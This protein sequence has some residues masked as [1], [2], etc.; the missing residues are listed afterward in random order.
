M[1]RP[2]AWTSNCVKLALEYVRELNSKGVTIVLTTHYLEE[3]QELCDQIAIINR[4]QAGGVRHH[5]YAAP[6]HG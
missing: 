3:A 6:P 1:S 2:P 5:H 4:G